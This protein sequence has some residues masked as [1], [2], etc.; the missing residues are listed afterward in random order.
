MASKLASVPT[1][2]IDQGVF[3][4]VLIE[5]S[6]EATNE[7]K[8]IVRGYTFAKFHD[9]V[10]QHVKPGIEAL[11]LA[12]S[13][14]GGGRIKHTPSQELFVYG[15]SVAFGQANHDTTVSLLKQAY[16]DIERIHFSNEGY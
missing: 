6:D 12:T 11:G 15:Y 7:R 8:Q 10:Y 4:Y 5:V 16:P 3:K 13:V 14:L 2:D 1:V 9:D